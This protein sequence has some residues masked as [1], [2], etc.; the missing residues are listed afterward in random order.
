MK[1]SPYIIDY[2]KFLTDKKE[3]IIF[4]SYLSQL[5]DALHKHLGEIKKLVD[6]D[7]VKLLDLEFTKDKEIKFEAF[8]KNMRIKQYLKIPDEISINNKNRKLL[9]PE[10]IASILNHAIIEIDNKILVLHFA[11]KQFKMHTIRAISKPIKS[12][13][14]ELK[15]NIYDNEIYMGIESTFVNYKSL[16]KDVGFDLSKIYETKYKDLN[17]ARKMVEEFSQLAE[18]IRK[19][20]RAY[21]REEAVAV[22]LAS[23]FVDVSSHIAPSLHFFAKI[24]QGRYD[25]LHPM[26]FSEVPKFLKSNWATFLLDYRNK[27]KELTITSR[28]IYINNKPITEI[29]R[30]L[31]IDEGLVKKI[32]DTYNLIIQMKQIV[33]TIKLSPIMAKKMLDRIPQADRDF[34]MELMEFDDRLMLLAIEDGKTDYKRTEKDEKDDK[35]KNLN[36]A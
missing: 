4:E 29:F 33:N 31:N 12:V 30:K 36:F 21:S 23:P 1:E 24:F 17:E 7:D 32:I 8:Y 15:A 26:N 11:K 13:T 10:V 20:Y 27:L 3:S 14:I 35:N 22:F 34:A 6:D 18:D 5:N 9:S 16:L 2:G 25:I 19:K 28:M